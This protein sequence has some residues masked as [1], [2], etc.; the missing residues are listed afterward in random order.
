[1]IQYYGNSFN[2]FAEFNDANYTLLV[3]YVKPTAIKNLPTKMMNITS[4]A[5]KSDDVIVKSSKML[6]V[7]VQLH[8]FSGSA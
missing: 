2:K 3:N 8:L 4:L 5:H 7:Q 6:N 1:M